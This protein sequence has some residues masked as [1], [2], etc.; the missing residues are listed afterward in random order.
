MET[1]LHPFQKAQVFTS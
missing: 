1:I